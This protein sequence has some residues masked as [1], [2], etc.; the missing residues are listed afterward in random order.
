MEELPK[1]LRLVVGERRTFAL[2]GLGTAGYVWDHEITG[3]DGV[4]SVE[5]ALGAPPGGGR[6]PVGVSAP[7]LVTITA[8]G[9]GR[10][11]V[12]LYQRRPWEPSGRVLTD[13][14]ITIVVE[15]P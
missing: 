6:R 7:Q 1:D 15:Q 2:A 13:H 12:R 14:T 9:L 4:V 8:R 10:A 3:P 11:V 5:W